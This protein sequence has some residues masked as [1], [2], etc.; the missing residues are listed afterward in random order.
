MDY[1][2]TLPTLIV[3]L[4]YIPLTFMAVNVFF[5]QDFD[6][7]YDDC[8]L[9]GRA[10]PQILEEN[11]EKEILEKCNEEER[12]KFENEKKTY[13]GYKYLFIVSLA[14][15]TILASILIKNNEPIVLGL[16]LGAVITTFISTLRYL[17]TRSKLGFVVLLGIFILTLYFLNKNSSYW[18]K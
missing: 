11:P 9:P 13:N 17:D 3:I 8:F 6:N 5:T 7:F 4:L 1:K 15:V 10:V 16:F 2:K 14:L 12:T 18:K